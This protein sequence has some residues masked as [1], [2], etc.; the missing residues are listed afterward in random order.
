MAKEPRFRILNKTRETVTLKLMDKPMT[1]SWEEFNKKLI[2]VDK[3]WAVLNEE[4]K[5]KQLAVAKDAKSSGNS[6]EAQILDK[7]IKK[8]NDEIKQ[9]QESNKKLANI[10]AR[11]AV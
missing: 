4:E 9:M 5:K 7:E 11:L 2:V 3:V 10:S 6:R 1:F 8:L